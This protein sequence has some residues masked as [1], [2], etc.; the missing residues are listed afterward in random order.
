LLRAVSQ[1][2]FSLKPG[3]YNFP[4]TVKIADAAP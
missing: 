1:T 2:E 3:V 4:A